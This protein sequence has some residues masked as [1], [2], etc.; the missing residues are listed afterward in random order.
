MITQSH[1]TTTNKPTNN[2]SQQLNLYTAH[3]TP[4]PVAPHLYTRSGHDARHRRRSRVSPL[5]HIPTHILTHR[6]LPTT[7]AA[8]RAPSSNGTAIY[9]AAFNAFRAQLSRQSSRVEAHDARAHAY[10]YIC[11]EKIA[12]IVYA[13]AWS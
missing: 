8:Q 10:T 13:R 12:F 11:S 9:A 7:R 6:P 1:H 5:I 2:N 4:S 3:I